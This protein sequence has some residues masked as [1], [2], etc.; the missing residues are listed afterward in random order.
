MR[1]RKLGILLLALGLLAMIV[2]LLADT[3]FGGAGRNVGFGNLQ[4][5]GL[6]AGVIVA[7]VGVWMARGG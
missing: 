2:S 3:I 1:D 7:A 6:I 5:L 4:L